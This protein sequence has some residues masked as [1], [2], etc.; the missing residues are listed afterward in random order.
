M[1][2]YIHSFPPPI[3]SKY[4]GVDYS[5]RIS[6]DSSASYL[7]DAPQATM[8]VVTLLLSIDGDSTQVPNIRSVSDITSALSRIA[9]DVKVGE[10]LRSAEILWTPEERSD[11]L[12]TRD[13]ISDY[14]DLTTI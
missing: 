14:P 4:G 1:A 9:S 11:T 8:A 10:C 7:K 3:V 2:H 12:S 6:A 5:P 13:I